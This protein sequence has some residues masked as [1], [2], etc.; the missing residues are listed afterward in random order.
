MVTKFDRYKANDISKLRMAKDF[1]YATL[2]DTR[3]ELEEFLDDLDSKAINPLQQE[4]QKASSHI[5]VR[6]ARLV[7]TQL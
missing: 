1:S 3:T 2:M 4:I 6:M 5:E 7:Y